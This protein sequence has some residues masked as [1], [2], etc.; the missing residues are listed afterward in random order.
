MKNIFLATAFAS[1]FFGATAQSILDG[2]FGYQGI[3]R[4]DFTSE[5]KR[6]C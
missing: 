2:S 4:T 1:F 5:K 3:V 6:P